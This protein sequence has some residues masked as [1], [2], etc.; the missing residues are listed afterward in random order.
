MLSRLSLFP[1]VC[2]AVTLLTTPPHPSHVCL[3][4]HPSVPDEYV[5]SYAVLIGQ[6]I[7]HRAVP[8]ADGYYEG[9]GYRIRVRELFRGRVPDS[10]EVFSENSTGRFPMK[11]RTTYLLFVYRERGRLMVDNCGNSGVLAPSAAALDT[12]RQ[13]HRKAPS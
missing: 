7:G 6:V 3:N 4:G 13:L 2:A 11:V 12:V 5:Q 10:F 9:D 8:E 1:V